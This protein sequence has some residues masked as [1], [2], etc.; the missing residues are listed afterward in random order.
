M[1]VLANDKLQYC[2]QLVVDCGDASEFKKGSH[3]ESCTSS[4]PRPVSLNS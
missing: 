2:G 1:Y 3:K 4:R